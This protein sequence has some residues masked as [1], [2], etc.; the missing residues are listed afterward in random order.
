MNIAEA[1]KI[2]IVD[3]LDVKGLK[4][5]KLYPGAAWYVSPM[6]EEHEASFKVHLGKNVWYDFGT[7]EGGTL[8]DLVKILEHCSTREALNYISAKSFSFDPHHFKKPDVSNKIEI[9]SIRDISSSALIQYLESRTISLRFARKYLREVTFKLYDKQFFALAFRNDKGGFELR[10][11]KFKGC[12]SPKCFTTIPGRND[13]SVN[14]FEGWSDFLS[15]CTFYNRQ[16]ENATIVLNSLAFL[17]K[18]LERLQPDQRINCVL[19]NDPAGRKATEGILGRFKIVTDYAPLLYPG[20]TDFNEFLTS[21]N[22]T[23]NYNHANL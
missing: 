11:R 15:M 17:P 8:I 19:D 1:K 6:R 5:A 21:I 18:V 10:N 9:V 7:G 20:H 22:N 13:Q 3:Y 23:K 12:T 16:P 14:I 4:P 2:Q